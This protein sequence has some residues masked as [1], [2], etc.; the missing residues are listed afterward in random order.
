METLLCAQMAAGAARW[1]P[2]RVAQMVSVL[3][4]VARPNRTSLESHSVA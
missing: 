2:S 4:G 3:N 1:V